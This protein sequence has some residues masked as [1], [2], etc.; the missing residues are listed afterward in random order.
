MAKDFEENRLKVQNYFTEINFLVAL[1]K[2]NLPYEIKEDKNKNTGK[3]E[4]L[5]IQNIPFPEDENFP[6]S[7]I[8]DLELENKVFSTPQSWKKG[9]KALIFLSF[10]TLYVIILEMKETLKPYE[11]DGLEGIEKKIVHSISRISMLLPIYLFDQKEDY[12]ELDIVYKA[13]IC[14]NKDDVSFQ[15]EKD[16]NIES[17]KLYK[18]FKNPKKDF[19][20][21]DTFGKNHKIDVIFLKNTSSNPSKMEIDSADIFR[22]NHDFPTSEYTE[23]S[24]P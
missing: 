21:V 5:T 22:D 23:L 15:A 18:A 11:S 6:K 17:I 7:W 13:I 1:N 3:L 4:S 24:C 14:Y 2:D 16:K 8:L 19:F 10:T 20:L 9:E 12:K